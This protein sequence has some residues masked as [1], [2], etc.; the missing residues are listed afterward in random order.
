MS[1]ETDIT[2]PW[3]LHT[4]PKHMLI[5][6]DKMK[7]LMTETDILTVF[8]ELMD[9]YPDYRKMYT[10]GSKRNNSVA[11]AFTVN[12]ALFSHKLR[13]GLS[14]YTA[15]LVAVREAMKFV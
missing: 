12:S 4:V 3:V 1:K 14:V 11:C 8:H 15:E 9:K 2:A 10:D 6:H 5:S 13:D 7:R